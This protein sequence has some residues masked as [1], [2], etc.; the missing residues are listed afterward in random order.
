MNDDKL[1]S[2]TDKARAYTF[3]H[4]GAKERIL[5]DRILKEIESGGTSPVIDDKRILYTDEKAEKQAAV[6]K[7]NRVLPTKK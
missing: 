3:A 7:K 2:I 1:R 6:Y 4:E 5:K